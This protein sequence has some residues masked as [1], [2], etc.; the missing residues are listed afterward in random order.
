MPARTKNIT[1][2]LI[3]KAYAELPKEWAILID[4]MYV[5]LSDSRR[6]LVGVVESLDWV[7]DENGN[8]LAEKECIELDFIEKSLTNILVKFDRLDR[9]Y[10]NSSIGGRP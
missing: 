7:Q 3:N 5:A 1:P 10:N 8:C 9:L 2:T 4:E 6:T